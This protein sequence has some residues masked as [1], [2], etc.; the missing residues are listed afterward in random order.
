VAGM[1]T[2]V[3]Q[4]ILQQQQEI[5]EATGRFSWLLSGITL[6]TKMVEAKIRTAGLSDVLG[7]FGNTN[8]QGEQQQKLDVYANQALLHCLGLRDSVAALVSEEDEEPVM[9]NR[10]LDTGK[11]IIV[12]D[13]LDGSSNIDVNV[14]VGTIFSILRR[15]S[16]ETNGVQDSILQPGYQQVA[17]GYVVYGPSTVLVYTTG[18]GVHGFTLDPTIGAFVLTSENMTMP[19]QGTY[20][21]VNEANASTWPDEYR[22]Y[23]GKLRSGAL[24]RQYS[25][26]YIGSLVADFHRTLLK[27]GVFLYPPTKDAPKGKLRLLYEANPLAFI[28]EQAGG[29]AS[30]GQMR[31]LDIKPEGIHQRTSFIVG[32]KREMEELL[33][34]RAK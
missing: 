13:P 15:L 10:S 21:S 25:S 27:G 6:A 29:M 1:I 23:V 18:N 5:H 2:T 12:F 28:A 8:V 34:G 17:A 7:A 33:D 16:T 11:Y 20:Y 19:E 31:I 9:F 30:N 24:G 22:E 14:N 4:H 32:S 3:Q 26:R